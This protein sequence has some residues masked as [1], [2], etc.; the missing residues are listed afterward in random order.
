MLC[1]LGPCSIH[2]SPATLSRNKSSRLRLEDC[3]SKESEMLRGPRP[4]T[5]RRTYVGEQ[6]GR[7][8]PKDVEEDCFALAY[9]GA[10]NFECNQSCMEK[11]IFDCCLSI[12]LLIFWTSFSLV[13]LIFLS[14]TP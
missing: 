2:S 10:G 7:L 5:E 8:A 11:T 13:S 4:A 1:L 14:M 3:L 12:C 9:L 6:H